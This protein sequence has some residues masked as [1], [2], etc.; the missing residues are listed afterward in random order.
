MTAA[1][2]DRTAPATRP[3]AGRVP[4]PIVVMF[5]VA[6]AMHFVAPD[7]YA[8]IVPRWLPGAA[9]IVAVSGAAEIAGGLGLIPL[10]TRRLAGWGLIALL[11]AVFPANVQMVIDAHRTGAAP[12]LLVVLWL[13]LPIQPLLMLW[14][15]GAA[16]KPAP[17]VVAPAPVAS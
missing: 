11:A 5:T 15:Y 2:P 13:R 6:G 9:S 14:V 1:P 10:A 4:W 3:P 16:V 8:Q 7:S 17:A 12:W